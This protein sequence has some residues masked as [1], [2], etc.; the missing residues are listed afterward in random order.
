MTKIQGWFDRFYVWLLQS[1]QNPQATSLAVQATLTA[2]VT[3]ATVLA[4]FGHVQLPTD[5]LT[6]LTD[7]IVQ[8]VQYALILISIVAGI[9]GVL[10]KLW[11]TFTGTHASLNAT[12]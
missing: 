4:G 2:L 3:Y 8:F 6:Q 12:R 5:L 7:G 1:S 11:A 10:R 9:W